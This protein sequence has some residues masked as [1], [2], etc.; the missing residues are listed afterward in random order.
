MKSNPII[1]DFVVILTILFFSSCRS[2]VEDDF[3]DNLKKPVVNSLLQADSTFSVQVTLTAHLG[4][5][6]FQP[7]KNAVVVIESFHNS[8]D[9]LSYLNSGLYVSDRIVESGETYTCKVI[10]P[11]YDT[12]KC[13]TTVP[14]RTAINGIKIMD[15]A[16]KDEEGEAYSSVKFRIANDSTKRTFWDVKLV[17]KNAYDSWMDITGLDYKYLIVFPEQDPVLLNEAMP[18]T[19]FSNLKMALTDYWFT[20]N[21]M[22]NEILNSEEPLYLELRSVDESYYY[23]QKQL[24]LY[25]TGLSSGFGET[26]KSYP[27]YSNVENGYG[28]FTSY[29]VDYKLVEF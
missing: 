9:T 29:A 10:I 26:A 1:I 21:V 12:L 11:G 13:H 16:G 23:Y 25:Q 6:L 18:F 7:V 22:K 24:Y 15:V 20:I 27:L 5:T 19:S 2:L 28:I 17:E 14:K 4:D 3:S 8:P